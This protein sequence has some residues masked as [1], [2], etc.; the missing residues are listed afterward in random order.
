MELESILGAMAGVIMGNGDEERWM[1][2]AS[3]NG[4]VYWKVI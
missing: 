1:E 2:R 4:K 3:S